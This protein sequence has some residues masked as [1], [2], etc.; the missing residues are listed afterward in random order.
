MSSTHF[1]CCSTGRKVEECFFAAAGYLTSKKAHLPDEVMFRDIDCVMV[2]KLPAQIG[3]RDTL[4]DI[5]GPFLSKSFE[6][7]FE[8]DMWSVLRRRAQ[9]SNST[10]PSG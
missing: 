2:P 7:S 10:K 4:L 5:Y 1:R 3:Y 8:S 9:L 6:P